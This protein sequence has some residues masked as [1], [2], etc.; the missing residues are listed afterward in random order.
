M[1]YLIYKTTNLINGKF[2]IGMHKTKVLE[3]GYLGS[4]KLLVRAIEKYG[5]DNFTREVLVICSSEEEMKVAERI[6]VVCDESVSY[7]LCPGGHGGFGFI[8]ANLPNGFK[9]KKQSERHHKSIVERFKN[10]PVTVRTREK[11]SKLAIERNFPQAFRGRTHHPESIEKIRS[12]AKGRVGGKNSQYG[13]MWITNGT[14]NRKIK[15]GS[16]IP[17]GYSPGRV[18]ESRKYDGA[19]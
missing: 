13:S 8:N 1:F 18:L 2:Y 10:N 17:Y 7:N 19:V 6:L 9:G 16:N 3:D 12:H 14:V 15:R 5:K 11:L 4:G